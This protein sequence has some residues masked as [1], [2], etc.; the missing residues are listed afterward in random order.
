MTSD[1]M[2]QSAWAAR[3]AMMRAERDRAR[4]ADDRAAWDRHPVLR[5]YPEMRPEVHPGQAA[6]HGA[7]GHDGLG[8]A[9]SN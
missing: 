4:A 5:Q 7:G 9:V 6:E 1:L 2:T 8:A 3:E